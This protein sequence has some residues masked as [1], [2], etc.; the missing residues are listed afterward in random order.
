MTPDEEQ[1]ATQPNGGTAERA[2]RPSSPTR[3]SRVPRPAHMLLAAAFAA[4]A[5]FRFPTLNERPLHTD[6]AV[7]AVKASALYDEGDYRYDPREYHGPTLPYL[8]AAALA[9]AGTEESAAASVVPYRIVVAVTGALLVLLPLLFLPGLGTRAAAVCAVLAA[10]SP[11]M[12]YY[13][14]YY[15][16]E[17]L[18]VAFTGLALAAGWRYLRRPGTG[19]AALFGASVGLMHATKET[20]VLSAAAAAGA[21]AV[22]L[23]RERRRT[24]DNRALRG[25]FSRVRAPHLAAAGIAA[26]GVILLLFSSFGS[27]WRGVL[28]SVLTIAT[29]LDRG[30][31][32]TVHDHPWHYYL[33]L[34][35]LPGT[36]PGPKWSEALLLI[37]GTAG[38]AAA[39]RP[40]R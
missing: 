35:F 24:R 9:L 31:G 18:L 19:W 25:L 37:L 8:T 27:H 40:K 15:I 11:A 34:Y 12:V 10:L 29:Y 20:W 4:A 17:M 28:D 22:L 7:Q 21:L 32:G 5:L 14:R 13:S 2:D 26:A 16:H 36:H 33:T 23:V 3:Q 6:E 39:W 1:D 38:G 30:S